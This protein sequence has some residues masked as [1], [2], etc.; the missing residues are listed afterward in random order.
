MKTADFLVEL[1]TEELPPKNLKL[2]M[3][4]FG[5]SFTSELQQAQLAHK[6]IRCFATPRRLA[7]LVT[8]LAAAQPDQKTEK[9]GPA[10]SAAF[11]A[12]GTPTKAALG[13]A[14]S[15][16]LEDPS[17]LDRIQTDK[18]EWLVFRAE[19]PGAA[20]PTL[21]E[22]ILARALA[23]L[24]IERPMRWGASRETFIR[25]VHWIVMIYGDQVVPARLFG[26]SA[27][28]FSVGHRFMAPHKIELRTA[29]D[30]VEALRENRVIVD[31]AE[32]RSNIEDQLLELGKSLGG[33]VVI[34]PALL[35]EVTSLVE[36]PVALCGRFDERFLSVPE[37]ALI[38]AMKSHQRYFHLLDQAGRL[39]PLFITISNINSKD[40]DIVIAG[41]ERVITPRLTDA[42]FF[43][44]QDSKT[45]LAEKTERLRDIVFQS[46]LG[47]Y[48]EKVERIAT[49]AGKIARQL[50]LDPAGCER[51]GFLAKAD[52]VS[53]MVGEFPELQG[54]MGS[55]YARNDGESEEIAVAI[56]EHYQPTQSGGA[57]PGSPIGQVVA[58]ADKLDTLAGIFGIG[59]PPTG[60]RDPFA[61]RRQALGVL[62]ICIE[63]GLDVDLAQMVQDAAAGHNKGFATAALLDYLLERLAGYYQERGIPADT[64]NAARYA[65]RSEW[66]LPAF[67]RQIQ[68]INAFRQNPKSGSL[69][70]ANK[71]VAN[72]L[73][74]VDLA[75]L[76]DIDPT[77][78]ALPT[79]EAL[80]TA[81]LA[82]TA[83]RT[84][85]D[86]LEERLLALAELQ[87]PIDGYFD[88]VLV[89]DKDETVRQNR[90]ATLAILRGLFLAVADVSML[91]T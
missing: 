63:G 7:I 46:S 86:T 43:Y 14:R 41:N 90:L 34:D 40:P 53:S 71:R 5:A 15:C 8:G 80:H 17:Q 48:Y 16:G 9:R 60:S 77:L 26:I 91:Q 44:E 37:E 47:T 31:F 11:A 88:D 39:M 74:P 85:S 33:R 81:I 6:G 13:F 55:Y 25:P 59:Q 72:L 19:Q 36:W 69:I 1:G 52:L 76:P 50:S 23:A 3:D 35:D 64:F 51:A 12:D 18:G 65:R 75:S 21:L 2:L 58:M 68:A 61:L 45:S 38:S 56:G 84:E 57:I 4:S 42:L 70:A 28:R 82:Y 83:Q 27:D 62:R 67:D 22:D 49:L 78:F 29:N 66:R 79:E 24:P 32:R 30:Y 20:T 89:M 73:K 54:L 87:E 10:V